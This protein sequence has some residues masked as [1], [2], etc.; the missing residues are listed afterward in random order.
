MNTLIKISFLLFVTVVTALAQ[1]QTEQRPIT[2]DQ[3]MWELRIQGGNWK[4]V[5]DRPV[6]AK[7][8]CTVSSFPEGEK[9]GT[10]VFVSDS[11]E[12]AISLFF[13][14]SPFPLG[15][16]TDPGRENR[17]EMKIQLSNCD[18]SNGTRI[19]R[20]I[21]KF[22]QQ[23]WVGAKDGYKGLGEY[24]PC[25]AIKPELNKEYILH[26]YFKEG[27]PYEAKATI[28]FLEKLEDESKVEKFVRGKARKWA[29]AGE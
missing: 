11:A 25:L 23:P 7:V 24:R 6:F 20:Y 28:C 18:A 1:N 13:M 27:D 17:K 9:T 8:V 4:F 16:Q 2:M 5:F 10:D 22:S 3:L 19:V 29:S 26:Y 14:V 12:K 15:G 21:D